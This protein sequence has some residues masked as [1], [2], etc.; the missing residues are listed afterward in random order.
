MLDKFLHHVL[1]ID[2]FTENYKNDP[3]SFLSKDESQVLLEN[4]ET[5]GIDGYCEGLNTY[6]KKKYCLQLA[7]IT[8]ESK[9]YHECVLP[10][11]SNDSNLRSH[12]EKTNNGWVLV[13]STD[14]IM[15]L[16]NISDQQIYTHHNKF[17]RYPKK[18]KK[19]AIN[20]LLRKSDYL[21]IEQLIKNE[22]KQKITTS[23]SKT[24]ISNK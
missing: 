4:S 19:K 2:T 1:D 23:K 5:N 16:L 3:D 6:L 22:D 11:I 24:A 13:K 12:Y 9:K 17:V 14:K 7:K 21:D 20:I 8:G 15:K 18:G 10:Y